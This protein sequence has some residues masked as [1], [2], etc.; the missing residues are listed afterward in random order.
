MVLLRV[1][2]VGDMAEDMVVDM[3]MVGMVDMVDMVVMVI[4]VGRGMTMCPHSRGMDTIPTLM[5]TMC[6]KNE[7]FRTICI[8][9][10]KMTFYRSNNKSNYNS[11][12]VSEN[13]DYLLKNNK[14]MNNGLGSSMNNSSNISMNNSSNISMNNSSNISMNNSSNISSDIDSDI[15]IKQPQTSYVE[16]DSSLLEIYNTAKN[17]EL[18]DAKKAIEY[19]NYINTRI[20]EIHNSNKSGVVCNSNYNNDDDND[21][22]NDDNS[23]INFIY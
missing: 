8:L 13:L 5:S 16:L 1:L 7:N 12:T 19:Y 6:K 18:A 15:I 2:E 23:H 20:S 3:D 14:N 22:V 9:Y 4:Q 10:V 11:N 17:C 21:T